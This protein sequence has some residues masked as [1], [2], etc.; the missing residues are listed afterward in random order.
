MWRWES[1]DPQRSQ[2]GSFPLSQEEALSTEHGR[3]WGIQRGLAALDNLDGHDLRRQGG[4][5]GD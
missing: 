3:S 2:K 5:E 4:Q 1:G